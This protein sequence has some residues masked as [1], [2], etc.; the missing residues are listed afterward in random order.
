M[1][2]ESNWIEPEKSGMDSPLTFY[3][4]RH[5]R[6]DLFDS[7]CSY[8]RMVHYSLWRFRVSNMISINKSFNKCDSSVGLVSILLS[9]C[10][11]AGL[12][13]QSE[14]PEHTYAVERLNA[15]KSFQI[16]Q[17]EDMSIYHDFQFA[18]AIGDSGIKFVHHIVD[19]AGVTYK[20]AHY[21]HGNAVAVADVDGDNLLDI[22][23]TTQ[24]G[25]NHLWKNLGNGKF[26]DVTRKAGVGLVNRVSVGAS[27]ADVDNDG[28]QDLFVTTVRH[29]NHLFQNQGDGSSKM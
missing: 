29:G 6:L 27:F 19:D 9:L 1:I 5:S 11:S 25:Y 23:W 4:F 24:M 10:G 20:A 8:R 18:D 21:D 7:I 16:K 26:E 12:S 15:R 22:Y 17:A 28:D 14:S 3:G 13:A 2:I